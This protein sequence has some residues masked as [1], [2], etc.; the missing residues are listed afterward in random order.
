MPTLGESITQVREMEG[1]AVVLRSVA[2]HLRT[3][4]VARDS[5]PAVAQ[6]R[7]TDGSPVP[8]AVIENQASEFEREA[9]SLEKAVRAA[10][11]AEVSDG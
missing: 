9:T 11:S 7:S 1:R 5:T 4:Y 8:E 10:K 6:M 2:S 3:K